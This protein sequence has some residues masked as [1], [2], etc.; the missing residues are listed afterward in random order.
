MA[1]WWNGFLE[2]TEIL[3]EQ[4]TKS[5][6]IMLTWQV[7]K[8]F[9]IVDIRWRYSDEV[10]EINK[11]YKND[12]YNELEIW[13]KREHEV[14][15]LFQ[16]EL[17]KPF[18]ELYNMSDC[19]AGYKKMFRYKHYYFQLIVDSYYFYKC[20]DFGENNFV[21]FNLA[22]Y[23]WKDEKFEKMQPENIAVIP[24]DDMMPQWYWEIQ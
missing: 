3:Y 1:S 5:F 11:N 21:F 24:D 23:G 18:R 7:K 13:I 2:K 6:D 16:K 20:R 22:L 9:E 10:D 14:G 12:I 19:V 15:R 4:M 17:W 8:N